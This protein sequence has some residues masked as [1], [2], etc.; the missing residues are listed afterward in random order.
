MNCKPLAVSLVLIWSGAAGAQVELRERVNDHAGV[1]RAQ[2][3]KELSAV[4][5]ELEQKT[6]A[7]V[8]VV[9]VPSTNGRDPYEYAS[10]LF[11]S[12]GR[13]RKGLGQASRNNG[14]LLLIAVNDR[15]W[16]IHVGEGLEGAL[17]D[18]YCD[19][20]AQEYFL[21]GFRRG[22]YS[23][24]LLAGTLALAGRIAAESGATL[25]GAPKVD[26]KPRRRGRGA[27]PVGAC[28]GIIFVCFLVLLFLSSLAGRSRRRSYRH[29]GSGVWDAMVIA[30]VLSHVASS[31]RRRGG[32]GWS[33]GGGFGGF[34]GGGGGSFGGGGAGGS[35]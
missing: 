29:W 5:A 3:K 7:Q 4:L 31:G 27:D 17:P 8:I 35:W 24:G 12:A 32:S 2:D 26:R 33:G 34:G 25:S 15:R 11:R 13:T 22:D 9:T 21:P 6:G 23:R 30:N 1:V 19:Q 14:V 16:R 20:I 10:D 18:L 28:V